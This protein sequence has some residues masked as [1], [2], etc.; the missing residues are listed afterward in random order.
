MPV[1]ERLW[2]LVI[3]VVMLVVTVVTACG[4]PQETLNGPE[5]TW[6]VIKSPITGKCYDALVFYAHGSGASLGSEVSCER[7]PR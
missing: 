6:V 5:T 2:F 7:L 1:G 4:S 3:G